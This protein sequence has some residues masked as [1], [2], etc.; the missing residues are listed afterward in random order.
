MITTVHA[1]DAASI[2]EMVYALRAQYRFLNVL[3]IGHSALGKPIYALVL[4]DSRERVL[5]AAAFHA[6]E[7]I[8]SLILLRL[9]ERIC[10]TLR[11]GERLADID[12][13]RALGGRGLMFVPLVNPDG[14]DIARHGAAAAG[15]YEPE[16]YRLGGDVYGKWQ[17][18][19][20]GVDLNH[21]FAAGWEILRKQEI[22]AGI[23]GPAARRFGGTAPESEPETAAITVLC[24]HTAFRHAIALHSQGEEIYWRY[25][26][27]TPPRSRLMAEIMSAASGYAVSD[28]EGLA[29]H[30]GFKD[31]F[32]EEFAAPGFTLE[33]GKG[34]NPLPVEELYGIYARIEEALL[35]FCLM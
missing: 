28:P 29:S 33:I 31:W 21:N 17:A 30:G 35:L 7:W 14:V 19:A 5:Y 13:R 22:A 34:E 32:I 10:H 3:P 26:E 18:N 4:G 27:H 11:V 1:V 24:R 23:L 15:L 16:V 12:L 6:Q 25:G 8:T 20:R 2:S 9:C